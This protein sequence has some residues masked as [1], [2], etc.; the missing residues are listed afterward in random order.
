MTD[1]ELPPLPVTNYVLATEG[2]GYSEDRIWSFNGYD[3]DQMRAYAEAAIKL[4]REAIAKLC[5]EFGDD[6]MRQAREGDNSGASY[7]KACAAVEIAE[8]IRARS[9][10]TPVQGEP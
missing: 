8:E 2:D 6:Y 5:D 4:E 1:N 7:H 10:S 9:P 3:D